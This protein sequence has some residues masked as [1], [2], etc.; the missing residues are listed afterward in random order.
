MVKKWYLNEWRFFKEKLFVTFLIVLVLLFADAAL[1]YDYYMRHQ[2]KAKTKAIKTMR[3]FEEHG[4][5]RKNTTE[6]FINLFINNFVF[7]LAATVSGFVPF[8]FLP[9]LL[10]IKS[11]GTLGLVIAIFEIYLKGDYYTLLAM[12][13]PHG[14]FEIPA[15]LYAT[16][17]GL[18]LTRQMSKKVIHRGTSDA[19]PFRVLCS[20][21]GSSFILVVIPLL[22]IA[23]FVEVFVTPG[24]FSSLP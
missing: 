9:I 13:L 22:L 24:S 1:N 20:K 23:A 21:A 5:L 3:S 7:S 10:V 18:Y 17:S 19:V 14:I 12:T 6:V 11:D 2:D 15:F 8:L 4:I 16:S